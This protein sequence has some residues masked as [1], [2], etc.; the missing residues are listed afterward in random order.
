MI[1][2][3]KKIEI[4]LLKRYDYYISATSSKS[5]RK[6]FK[7]LIFRIEIGYFKLS[8]MENNFT[9]KIIFAIS[10]LFLSLLF[11]ISPFGIIRQLERISYRTSVG[12]QAREKWRPP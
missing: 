11:F 5:K 2:K 4:S 8:Y 10:I 1:S 9:K 7:T 3:K 12:V 6:I